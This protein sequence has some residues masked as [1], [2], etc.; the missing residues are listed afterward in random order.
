MTSQR[1]H[2]CKTVRDQKT[3]IVRINRYRLKVHPQLDF[4]VIFS[5][6]DVVE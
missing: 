4:D 3:D 2:N 1:L 6:L 5:P